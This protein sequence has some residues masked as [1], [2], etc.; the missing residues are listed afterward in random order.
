M[1]AEVELFRPPTKHYGMTH[2]ATSFMYGVPMNWALCCIDVQSAPCRRIGAQL[3]SSRSIDWHSRY[4]NR[5]VCG[6]PS[7]G[8]CS[9]ILRLG[10]SMATCCRPG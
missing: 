8:V 2:G 5:H 4:P 9:E 10:A 1:R 3:E 6:P 7:G